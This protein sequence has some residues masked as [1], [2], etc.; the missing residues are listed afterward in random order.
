MFFVDLL[1]RLNERWTVELFLKFFGWGV[2]E[3]LL[4]EIKKLRNLVM[5]TKLQKFLKNYAK[6][7]QLNF[8]ISIILINYWQNN[9]SS[10]ILH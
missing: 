6:Y 9:H 5:G 8:S 7:F 3:Q 2:E 10:M 4:K 1:P